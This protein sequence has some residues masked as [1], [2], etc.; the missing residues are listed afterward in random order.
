MSKEP[1]PYT[2][3]VNDL[4]WCVEHIKELE[5]EIEKLKTHHHQLGWN[6]DGIDITSIPVPDK[7]E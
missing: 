5:N 1:N 4:E 2:T 7:R 6:R 3:I